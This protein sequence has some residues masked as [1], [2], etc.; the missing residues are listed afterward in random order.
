MRAYDYPIKDGTPGWTRTINLQL[1][2]LLL[3]P[4]ELRELSIENKKEIWWSRG[5]SNPWPPACKAGALANWATTPWLFLSCTIN[6]E[7]RDSNPRR[8]SSAGLQPAAFDRSATCPLIKYVYFL[9]VVLKSRCIGWSWW[10]ESKDYQHSNHNKK[11][12][13]EYINCSTITNILFCSLYVSKHIIKLI[14]VID[15]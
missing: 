3:Y 11:T 9:C 5:E 1:R 8:L 14:V 6:W 15:Y 2:R 13:K 12:S 10:S 4:I 7:G